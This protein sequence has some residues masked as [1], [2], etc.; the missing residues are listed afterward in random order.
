[1]VEAHEKISYSQPI[2]SIS[3]S[4]NVPLEELL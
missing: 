2:Q 4:I 3:S 1:M